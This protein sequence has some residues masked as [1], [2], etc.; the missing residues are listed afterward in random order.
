VG[1][2]PPEAL[3]SDDPVTPDD[4]ASVAGFLQEL[5][6]DI[7][8]EGGV[9]KWATWIASLR[10]YAEHSTKRR[11][12]IWAYTRC[13]PHGTSGRSHRMAATRQTE[14]RPR[15]RARSTSSRSEEIIIASARRN[16]ESAS[17]AMGL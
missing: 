17:S 1:G 15:V 3:V 4:V 14:A 11:S 5:A 8:R 16:E 13:Q 12:Q 7:D 2:D 6:A 10:A 9:E